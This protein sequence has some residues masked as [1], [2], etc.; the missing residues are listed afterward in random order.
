M[1]DPP[2]IVIVGGGIAGASIAIVLARRGHSV[3]VLEKSTEH[4][5]KVRGESITPWGVAEALTLD[6]HDILIE[7]G[8]HFASKLIIYGEG[9][10]PDA[11]QAGAINI[12]GLIPGVGG[13]LKLGHPAMCQALDNAAVACGVRLLRAV[14][15]VEV[16]PGAPPTIAFR[17]D[18]A[19][20]ELQPKLIIGADG[21][22]SA[23]AKQIGA[24]VQSDPLHH[25]FGGLLIDE[26]PDWPDDTMV[27]GTEGNG[28]FYIFPQ[29]QGRIRL[30]YA[31]D[32]DRRREFNG[33]DGAANFLASFRLGTV[34]GSEWVAAAHPAGP[35]QGYPNADTWVDRPYAPGVV[36]IGDAAG[37]NDPT[38]GQGISIAFR[39]VRLV[40]EAL[41][42]HDDWTPDIFAPY[43]AERRRRMRRLRVTAQ[44][45]SK[46]RCVYT[47]D[48][49]AKRFRA[50]E[51]LA[52]DPSL[53]TPFR[54]VLMGPD[55]LP[56]DAYE[57]AVWQR[58]FD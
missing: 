35:C 11:A 14:R 5:D 3:L 52:K 7:A 44:Q 42:A 28:T 26:C 46:Y 15:R 21:R 56:D 55:L 13:N 10:D 27:T 41:A 23:V 1:A 25:I 47:E 49:R 50:A 39:D 30:Y 16:T 29:G 17:H 31:Y 36:L 33:P 12:S 43:A 8:G 9:I 58:L 37:H 48:A 22:G 6:L 57:P 54:A 4:I 34:P 20:M 18:G 40:A 2:D 38:I 24:E 53:A 51:R 19:A 45:F 32:A